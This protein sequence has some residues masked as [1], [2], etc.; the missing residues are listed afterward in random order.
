MKMKWTFPPFLLVA[1]LVLIVGCRTPKHIPYFQGM[2]RMTPDGWQA[3][4]RQYGIL[5]GPDDRLA[6]TVSAWD[7]DAVA[8]FNPSGYSPASTYST[9]SDRQSNQS[10]S[11]AAI[12]EVSSS[13]ITYQ[14]DARGYIQFPVVG[15]V[16]VAGLTRQQVADKLQL[17]ISRYIEEPLVHIQIVNFKVN[18]MG[19]VVYPGV[20]TFLNERI[21][22]LDALAMAGD[23]TINGNRQRVLVIREVDGHKEHTYLDLSDV[24]VFSSPFFYLKQNDVIYVEPNSAKIQDSYYSQTRQYNISLFSSIISAVNIA[25]TLILAISNRF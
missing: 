15:A 1:G 3:V 2:D 14:V 22:I 16:H 7:Q 13:M 18:V 20:I 23:L 24:S 21:S 9:L 10:V 17:E 8:P 19:E 6:I 12:Q 4:D 25:A 5:I 11:G